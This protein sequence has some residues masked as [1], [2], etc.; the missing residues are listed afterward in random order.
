MEKFQTN[1]L[2]PTGWMITSHYEKDTKNKVLRVKRNEDGTQI[3]DFHKMED[4]DKEI[5]EGL[6]DGTWSF[7]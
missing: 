1:T 3:K 7:E 2:S 5:Q 4:F 6:K